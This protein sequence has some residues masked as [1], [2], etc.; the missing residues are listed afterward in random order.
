MPQPKRFRDP[1]SYIPTTKNLKL[2]TVALLKD[3][4][5]RFAGHNGLAME[6]VKLADLSDR[7]PDRVRAKDH[8]P[9]RNGATDKISDSPDA[10]EEPSYQ[11]DMEEEENGRDLEGMKDLASMLSETDKDLL[12]KMLEE[13]GIDPAALD[14]VME[15]LIQGKQREFGEDEAGDD[16]EDIEDSAGEGAS[17]RHANADGATKETG[18]D[19]LLEAAD[20]SQLLPPK[21]KA[22]LMDFGIDDTDYHNDQ[23]TAAPRA[24][25]SKRGKY[26][27]QP[28]TEPST[29]PN[30]EPSTEPDSVKNANTATGQNGTRGNG[31]G[32][33]RKADAD[34]GGELHPKRTKAVDA[35]AQVVMGSSNGTKSSR[36]TRSLHK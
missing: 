20:A 15:D 8:L 34:G 1:S 7:A 26:R 11:N 35:H 33:K 23:I 31:A 27:A 29:K 14:M 22:G 9:L 19:N 24:R 32:I 17:G 30:T 6:A 36:G 10:R 16:E 18:A 13:K 5:D 25:T 12:I 4:R 3:W 2:S 21:R 28:R